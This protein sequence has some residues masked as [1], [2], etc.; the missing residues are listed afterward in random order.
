MK[1]RQLVLRLWH[2]EQGAVR[3]ASAKRARVK[4]RVE[5]VKYMGFA[6]LYAW[7]PVEYLGFGPLYT[8][9]MTSTRTEA[10]TRGLGYG[11]GL[12]GMGSRPVEFNR[13]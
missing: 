7:V 10:M 1:I 8:G 9:A 4:A 11:R 13:L 12:R 5:D 3:P 2:T 6:R